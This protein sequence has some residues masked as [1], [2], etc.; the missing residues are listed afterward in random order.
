VAGFQGLIF[1]AEMRGNVRTH[2]A[3]FEGSGW[4]ES[5]SAMNILA[6]RELIETRRGEV[7]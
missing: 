4:E 1:V 3:A 5:K 6:S 2:R 7:A